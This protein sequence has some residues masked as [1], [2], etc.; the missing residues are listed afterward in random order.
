[1]LGLGMGLR[2]RRTL[3]LL[4]GVR[5][6]ISGSGITTSIGP[7]GARITLGGKRTRVTTGIPGTG[8]SYTTLLPR[9][10]S[11]T[12]AATRRGTRMPYGVWIVMAFVV[13]AIWLGSNSTPTQ[14]SVE[15]TPAITSP[16]AAPIALVEP[17]NIGFVAVDALNVRDAPNGSI[18]GSMARGTRVDVYETA[19]GWSRLSMRGASPRWVSA[20]RICA[21]EGCYKQPLLRRPPAHPARPRSSSSAHGV[22]GRSARFSME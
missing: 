18:V 16:S 14:H 12:G 22:A 1:M 19:N 2:F 7:R 8:L 13:A 17:S 11:Q 5:L 9:S 20:S 10:D 6:N 15:P 3:K 4:P 21:E